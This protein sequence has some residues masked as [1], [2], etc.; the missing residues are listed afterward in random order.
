VGAAGTDALVRL[1]GDDAG[2]QRETSGMARLVPQPDRFFDPGLGHPST[3]RIELARSLSNGRECWR[4]T[5]RIAYR[6]R[7]LGD[8]IVPEPGGRGDTDL[9]SVPQFFTWLVPKTGQHLP[10]ALVH[11]GLTPPDGGGFEIVPVR[12]ITQ[13]DADRVFRDAM[14]DLGTP[15]VRRWLVWSAVSIPT[16]RTTGWWRAVLAYGSIALVVV[17][18][19]LATLDLLEVT[20]V[21][22]WMSSPRWWVDLLWGGALAV[23]IPSLLALLW[24]PKLRVA[25]FVVGVSIALLLHVTVAVLLVTLVYRVLEGAGRV[26]AGR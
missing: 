9:T 3:P 12:A 23:I 18:G 8:I 2:E 22:P 17:L 19:V 11:D 21:L 25:G 5:T 7:Q 26:V 6:D 20:D 15:P 14:A 1:S 24:P 10:A 4:M 16:V 13:V